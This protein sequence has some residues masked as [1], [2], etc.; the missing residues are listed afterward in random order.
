MAKIFP[1]KVVWITGGGSGIGRACA[2]EFAKRGADVAVSGRRLDR[3]E[4]TC[5]A[6]RDHGVRA[7]AAPC[8]V[9]DEARL[10]EVVGEVV[11]AFGRLDLAMANAGFSAGGRIEDLTA[12]D[13]RRQFDINVVAAAMTARFSLPELR[14]QKGRIML[15]GSVAGFV[16]GP[17]FG[18]YHASKHA[19]RALGA[20]L[21]AELFGSGGSCTTVHPGFV[22]S[23]IARVDNAG[24]F[25]D[26]R[27][28]KR[29]AS[30]MWT[31][32]R[33]ARVMVRAAE[34]RKRELVFTGHGKIAAF[35]GMHFPSLTYRFMTREKALEQASSFRVE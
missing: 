2:I 11:G 28:D 26:A 15:V 34:K 14:K 32:E 21:S 20:T 23:E 19:V 7:L 9:R 24:Q 31:A 18:A 16:P 5:A 22:E 10:E 4:E 35:L 3:L 27:R 8:D 6:V 25:D 33:A 12:E 29:P 30:L 17:H 1:G 13:W